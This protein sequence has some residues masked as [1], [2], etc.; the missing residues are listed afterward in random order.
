M[1]GVVIHAPKDLRVED[2]AEPP[3][4]PRDI[5]VQV[6][7]GGIC[8]SDL[9]YFN[10]GGSGAIR[11]REPMV[12]GHEI[13]GVVVEI[14]ASV[15]S[16][17]IGERV[18]VDPSRACGR[19]VYCKEGLRNHCTDMRFMGSAM[20]FPH[21]QGGFCERVAIDAGQGV[22]VGDHI[23]MA[24]AAMAEPLAVCLHAV[25]R[26]GPLLGRRVL[27]TGCG[28]IGI[29]AIAAARLA[30]AS[31]VVATDV[32]DAALALARRTGAGATIN[33]A[34]DPDGLAE[35]VGRIGRIDVLLEASGNA[36]VLRGALEHLR[37]RGILVQLGLGGDVSLPINAIVAR[38]IDF[39]GTFRFDR[40]FALAVDLI[41]RGLIDVKP[42]ITATF[43]FED[44]AEAF[45]IAG[46]RSRMTKVQLG[47]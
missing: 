20:R 39:R 2:V 42:L 15:S 14:G 32:Q 11:I 16:V 33:V 10:H 7:A 40:E 44:A 45:A 3:L 1:R 30:G 36:A 8:G 38:E 41:D 43:P 25:D 4:G 24:E 5:R 37:P 26:A 21:M 31:E 34:A 9:H 29:L 35:C 23:T 46:D 6:A 22:P 13:A 27:V 12:L 18:A 17:A 19:C 28:P 47:F